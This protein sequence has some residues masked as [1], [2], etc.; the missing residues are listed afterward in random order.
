MFVLTDEQLGR[1]DVVKHEINTGSA[2]PIKHRLRH[3]SY[4]AVDENDLA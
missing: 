1:T 3:L 4:Y 2:K